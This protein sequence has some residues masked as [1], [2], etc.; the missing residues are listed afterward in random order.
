MVS[1]AYAQSTSTPQPNPIMSFVPFVLIF[2]VF[3]FLMI[4]PQKKRMEQEKGFLAGLKKGDNVYT[5][6]GVIGAIVGLTE[7]VV[8]LE[9]AQGVKLKVLRSQIADKTDKLFKDPTLSREKSQK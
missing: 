4:R 8:D 1:N 2:V 3:Y 6:S 9:V 5:K 7:K